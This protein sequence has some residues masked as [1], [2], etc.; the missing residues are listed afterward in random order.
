MKLITFKTQHLPKF[1][2]YLYL[3]YTKSLR[4]SNP[5]LLAVSS[6]L[7]PPLHRPSVHIIYFICVLTHLE[8]CPPTI[9]S[10]V[11]WLLYET[12]QKPTVIGLP[13]CWMLTLLCVSCA[14]S[15]FVLFNGFSSSVFSFVFC[16]F[17][18]V[19]HFV[20]CKKKKGFKCCRTNSYLNHITS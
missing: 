14:P 13:G 15:L 11:C 5:H 2:S 10:T 9:R 18:D 1:P 12:G 4:S 17:I 19:T 16:I 6:P 20:I 8:Q 7:L 3:P